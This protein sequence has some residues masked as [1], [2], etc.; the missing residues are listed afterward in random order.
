MKRKKRIH[1]AIAPSVL[2][3]TLSDHVG[4]TRSTYTHSVS[5]DEIAL[6]EILIEEGR[7]LSKCPASGHAASSALAENTYDTQRRSKLGLVL[8]C[9]HTP[10]PRAAAHTRTLPKATVVAEFGLRNSDLPFTQG[11]RNSVIDVPQR[12]Q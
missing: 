11:R 2:S 8:S 7:E 1:W 12:C 3:T 9:A 6:R 10:H 5:L 4:N